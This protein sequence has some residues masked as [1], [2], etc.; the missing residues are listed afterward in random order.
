M[1][2]LLF[3]FLLILAGQQ[4]QAQDQ[5]LY[6]QMQALNDSLAAT[7]DQVRKIDL[8]LERSQ[9][10]FQRGILVA[11]LG[12]ATTI[13][14][15]LM[16]GRKNDELGQGLLVAGGVTGAV[17]TVLLVDAFSVFGNK[18]GKKLRRR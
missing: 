14:G 5:D 1:R 10:R 18:K 12:Y 9:A 4:V 8:K 15:G 7:Q 11:T 3:I 16:L 13:A 6:K 2:R 17:G